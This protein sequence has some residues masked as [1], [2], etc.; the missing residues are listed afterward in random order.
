MSLQ[1]DPAAVSAARCLLIELI[2]QY[3]GDLAALALSDAIGWL[4]TELPVVPDVTDLLTWA[5][6]VEQ[7]ASDLPAVDPWK[8]ALWS[9]GL[10]LRLRAK[11]LP[12][13]LNTYTP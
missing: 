11:A 2:R 8:Q 7:L 5:N 4:E 10:V 1:T 3:P 12:A 13:P 9:E 6:A